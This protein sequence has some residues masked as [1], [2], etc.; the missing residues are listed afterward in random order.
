LKNDIIIFTFLSGIKIKQETKLKTD[1]QVSRFSLGAFSGCQYVW[2]LSNLTFYC[3]FF[4]EINEK[5]TLDDNLSGISLRKMRV[6]LPEGKFRLP[7][8]Y[9]FSYDKEK[10]LIFSTLEE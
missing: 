3:Y 7:L 8:F 4:D 1:S 9:P 10:F 6:S 5:W 2:I